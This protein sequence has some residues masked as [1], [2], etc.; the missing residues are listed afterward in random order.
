[1]TEGRA[2]HDVEVE[3]SLDASPSLVRT[4]NGGIGSMVYVLV[5][6]AWAA[7][8]IWDETAARLRAFGHTVHALT[9]SGLGGTDG[10]ASVDLS[11][12]VQDV[13]DH[14]RA[15]GLDRVVL[16][17]HSYAGVVVGQVAAS[18]PDLVAHTVYVNAFL[19]VEGKSLL[20][21]SGL[22]E[23]LER[24]LIEGNAGL[25]PAPE[26]EEL[27]QQVSLAVGQAEHLAARLVGHPGRSVTAPA[28][29]ARPL[30]TL[31]STY[32]AERG[33]GS[34]QAG[35]L[36]ALSAEPTWN[37]VTMGGGHWPMLT[38]PD[39]LV[40]HLLAAHGPRRPEPPRSEGVPP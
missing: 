35:L 8:W 30:S 24:R 4:R 13:L 26:L 1:M 16:V 40:A 38:V 31:R 11:I 33:W 23:E 39:D 5:P 29:M 12:H 32:I 21:V 17:G 27:R 34:A 14:I 19:P 28:A 3:A 6:G 37:F 36:R 10:A 15:R 25:W 2:A 20:E 9:L 18:A 7:D 22:D